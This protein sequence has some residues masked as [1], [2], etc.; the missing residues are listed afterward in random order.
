MAFSLQSYFQRIGYDGPTEPTLAVLRRL[1]HWHTQT[2][3][4]ENIDVLLGKPVQ[5]EREAIF[6]KLVHKQR[7]G[8]CFEQNGLM[9]QVLRELG[10]TVFPLGARVRLRQAD[11][12][13]FPARTHLFSAVNIDGVYW[14]VDVGFGALTLTAPLLWQES[15][16][17]HQSREPRRLVREGKRWFHQAWQ[18][19]GWRDVYE[20]TKEPMHLADQRV[21][22]WYTSTHPDSNFTQRLSL[23]LALPDGGRVTLNG[24][25]L[26]VL[27]RGQAEQRF[28]VGKEALPMILEQH[29]GI[30]LTAQECATLWRTQTDLD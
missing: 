5:I 7:G 14:L 24:K 27:R 10:Y 20:F 12:E 22:N 15:A 9:Q 6:H 28:R 17:Q 13:Q 16:L 4:F 19:D 3:P 11:R 26:R 18:Q 25:S 1:V 8:Y 23:A 29:F 21:A 2:I 30:T